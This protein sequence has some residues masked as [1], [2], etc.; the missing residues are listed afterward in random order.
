[1]TFESIMVL[2]GV[3][4]EMGMGDEFFS[5]DHGSVGL[6]DDRIMKLPD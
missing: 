1:M 5:I 4:V 2:F 3:C 6:I